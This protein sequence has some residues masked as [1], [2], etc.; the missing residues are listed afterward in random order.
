MR[1][2]FRLVDLDAVWLT[3]LD[4]PQMRM[5]VGD[6]NVLGTPMNMVHDAGGNVVSTGQH[7]LILI[8]R[9]EYV[10]P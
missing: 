9:P 3:I 6:W 10:L 2:A 1:V 5:T 8:V 7:A 4:L